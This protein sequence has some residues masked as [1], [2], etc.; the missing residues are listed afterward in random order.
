MIYIMNKRCPAVLGVS[1]LP[2]N[3][4][5]ENIC[6]H[7]WSNKKKNNGVETDLEITMR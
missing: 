4:N 5:E 3:E 6:S 7:S 1:F 2:G